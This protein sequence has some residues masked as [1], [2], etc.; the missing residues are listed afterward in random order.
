M[1]ALLIACQLACFVSLFFH[2]RHKYRLTLLY[3][4]LAILATWLCR[5]DSG[6]LQRW[7]PFCVPVAVLR[8]FAGVEVAHRQTSGFKYWGRLMGAVFLMAGMFAGLF[9]ILTWNHAGNPFQNLIQFRRLIQVYAGSM[10]LV[11]EWFWVTMG[12][13]WYRR[14][15]WLAFWFGVLCMNH[16]TVGVLAGAGMFP[17]GE[18]WKSAESWS[19]AVDD[20][21]YLCMGAIGRFRLPLLGETPPK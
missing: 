1:K 15:D 8:L 3:L 4:L 16:A 21:C 12:G 2:L 10:F 14:S 20:L 9:G 11:L 7:Y 13:G 17:T 18:I 19:S 5:H 6:W